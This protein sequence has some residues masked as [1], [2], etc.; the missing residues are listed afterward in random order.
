MIREKFKLAIKTYNKIAKLYSK[1]TFP[2]INQYHLNKFISMLPKNAKVLD[3]GCGSGKDAQYFN[4]Y[5]LDVIG[6]DAAKKLIEEAKKNVKGVKFKTMD[7]AK[8]SFKDQT[9]DGIWAAGSLI[10]DEKCNI[11]TILEELKRILKDD[12]VIYVAVKEGSG[13][14]MKKEAVY[15][16][17]PRPFFY[18]TLPEIEKMMEQSGFQIIH[19]RFDEDVLKRKDTKWIDVY[20]KKGRRIA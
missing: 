9:F 6:I 8:T 13:E 19:S 17:E 3:A 15:N 11:P 18:Y 14:E 10:H 5:G 4:D 1:V 7:M 12:G 20:C 2:K 16:N